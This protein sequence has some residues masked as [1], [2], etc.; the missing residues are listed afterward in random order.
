[1]AALPTATRGFVGRASI[2]AGDCLARV[3]ARLA[4]L[5]AILPILTTIAGCAT[6]PARQAVPV[7]LVERV[8]VPGLSAT[9]F[10]GD[11]V[12][13]TTLADLQARLPNMKAVAIADK[14]EKGRPVVNY[15]ALSG[16]GADGA[17]G[18]GLLVGW[19]EAGTRPRFEVVTGVSTGAIIA[20]F[21]FLG[22]RCDD[23]L[24][25]V[26]TQYATADL[27]ET[28]LLSGL[29]GGAALA[30][31][32]PLAA[33]IAKYIDRQM[34]DEVAAQY[35]Q[36]RMLLIGTTNLDA[37]RPVIWNMGEIATSRHPDALTLFRKVIL[38]S[39][40]I[41]GV[42]PPVNIQVAADGGAFEEM[43]VDG[44]PT[45]QV[46]LVPGQVALRD[47]DVFYD[48]PPIRRIYII[49]N[50]KLLPDYEPAQ[51]NALA[52]TAKTITTLIMNQ[53][54]GDLLRI[55][56]TARQAGADFNLA[57]IPADFQAPQKEP[58]DRRYMQEL[59]KTGAQLAH[60]GYK[61][62]KAPPDQVRPSPT[63]VGIALR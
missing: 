4:F 1:M 23:S 33:L 6:A 54:Q 29:F 45:R 48:K 3:A 34:L 38:A 11:E 18:A 20:T 17:F 44:G 10:W 52:I 60:D 42:F 55:Y 49:R 39:A 28:Q 46:F 43:H 13:G 58:F 31:S 19:S 53:S 61:W 7:A 26:F 63:P 41:P 47:F 25:E 5:L 21:A 12:R 16:G 59:F 2:G 51:A 9:R 30:D 8:D 32:K 40:S 24:R 56:T 22:P 14:R 35:R 37:Q 36:G 62:S 50:A 57:A 27:L 15:L